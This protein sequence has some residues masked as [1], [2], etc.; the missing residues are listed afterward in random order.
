MATGSSSTVTPISSNAIPRFPP[1][2]NGQFLHAKAVATSSRV[3]HTRYASSNVS[4]KFALKRDLSN[5]KQGD[6]DL[7]HYYAKLAKYW[8]EPEAISSVRYL[9]CVVGDN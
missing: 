7:A 4:R 8:E 3:L 2:V 6:L 5:M 9:N 1:I